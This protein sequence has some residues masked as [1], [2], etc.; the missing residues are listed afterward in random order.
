MHRNPSNKLET[1]G[2]S[3]KPKTNLNAVDLYDKGLG[4]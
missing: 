2:Q 4:G 1:S 3:I